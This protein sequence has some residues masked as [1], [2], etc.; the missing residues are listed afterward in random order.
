MRI[1]LIEPAKPDVSLAGE[2]VFI[3]EPLALEYVAAGVLDEHEV[4]ILDMRLDKNLESVLA[5]FRPH[6]VGA[7]AFTVHVNGVKRLLERVKAQHTDVLTVVGG[8]HATVAP[9]D[10]TSPGIDLVVVGE[11][12]FAFRGIVGRLQRGEEFGGIPGVVPAGAC[13]QPVTN[14]GTHTDLDA[15]PFPAR[16]LTSQYRRQYYSEWMRPLAS[17]RT[18]TGFERP[19]TVMKSTSDR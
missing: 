7:T 5:D 18:T 2:D 1:L 4:K 15:L 14:G 12:V 8:H 11:G 13:G 3:Y 6:V 10:F 16:S 19:T 17:I 9:E